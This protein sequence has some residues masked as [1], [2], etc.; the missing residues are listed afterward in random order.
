M[1]IMEIV[2]GQS[3][4]GAVIH[5]LGL[6]R[7]L[8]RLGHQITLVCRPKSWISQQ[9]AP[10]GVELIESHQ[11]CFSLADLREVSRLVR[12]RGIEIVHTHQNRA[13]AMG[14]SLKLLTGVP[15][16]ATAHSRSLQLHWM[17]NDHVISVSRATQDYQRRY[18]LCRSSRTSVIPCFVD[19]DASSSVSNESRRN[20]RSQFDFGPDQ[21]LLGMVGE[22]SKRKGLLY[23]VKALPAILAIVPQAKVLI[24]GREIKS[25]TEEVRSIAQKLNVSQALVWAGC[26]DDVKQL[27]P[28]LDLFVLPSLEEQIPLAILEAMA[29]GLPVVATHVGGIP[30]CIDSGT[31]GVLIPPAAPEPLAQ[32]IV[33][34]L[35]ERDLRTTMGQAAQ[36]RIIENYSPASNAKRVEELMTS[37]L[38]RR[39]RKMSSSKLAG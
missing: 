23:L 22:V 10:A 17:W 18:N 19:V 36:R 32:A 29:C 14:V 30:E 8:A 6:S 35:T 24:V 25:Y 11:Y 28:A 1:R 12:S 5:C 33:K 38:A 9:I 3:V 13:S 7:E 39:R 20:T 26:R 4:N 2:S 37:V 31:E 15:A 16:V 27:L 21:P 34:L